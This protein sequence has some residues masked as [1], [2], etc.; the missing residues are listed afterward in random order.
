MDNVSAT[1]HSIIAHVVQLY[2]HIIFV[3]PNQEGHSGIVKKCRKNFHS[4]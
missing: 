4:Y 2:L 3:Q 1:I